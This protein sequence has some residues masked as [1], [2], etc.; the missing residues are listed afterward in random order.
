MLTFFHAVRVYVMALLTLSS[1]WC[2]LLSS[3][4]SLAPVKTR[5]AANGK[6]TSTGE[7]DVLNKG[8]I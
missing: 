5:M 6:T 2:R 4:A 8:N 7:A 3:T 1:V